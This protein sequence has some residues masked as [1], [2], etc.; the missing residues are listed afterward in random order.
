MSWLGTVPRDYEIRPDPNLHRHISWDGPV[1]P[2]AKVVDGC[3]EVV[4]DCDI[5]AH[6]VW[7]PMSDLRVMTS[8]TCNKCKKGKT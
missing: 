4:P 8:I 7:V 5:P 3:V 1:V 6:I 2:V